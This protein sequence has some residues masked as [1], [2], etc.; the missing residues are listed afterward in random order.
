MF[1]TSVHEVAGSNP[2]RG[3]ILSQTNQRF[4]AQNLSCSPFQRPDMAEILLK[5][6]L[7]P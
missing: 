7:N 2:T 4:I 5:G 6:M 3:E 1:P